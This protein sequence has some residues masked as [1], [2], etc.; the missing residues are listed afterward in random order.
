M[1]SKKPLAYGILSGIGIFS[2]FMIILSAFVSLNFA[3]S[4]FNRLWFFILPLS[5]GFGTQIGLYTAIK[6][7]A[8]I[9][10]GVA[11]SGTVSG[12]SMVACCSHFLLSI[13]PLIGLSGLATFLMAY[14]KTF[15]SIGIASSLFGIGFMFHHKRK[16]GNINLKSQTP[17]SL[18]LKGGCH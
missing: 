4:E 13:I 5:A 6:H 11:T 2:F 15:F 18:H 9:N 3:L 8:T 1:K 7:S 17:Q 10:A 14:Q 12:G 16:M